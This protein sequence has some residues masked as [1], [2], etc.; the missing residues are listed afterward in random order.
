MQMQCLPKIN[1]STN[2]TQK[3]KKK[4]KQIKITKLYKL[5]IFRIELNTIRF[6]RSFQL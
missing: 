5:I 6:E 4:K 1:E 2:I 3:I